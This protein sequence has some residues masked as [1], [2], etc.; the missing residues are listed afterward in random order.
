MKD[1]YKFIKVKGLD[2]A[3]KSIIQALVDSRGELKDGV[4]QV[5]NI[6]YT[7]ARA[8][9]PMV[10]LMR[11]A[12]NWESFNGKKIPRDLR[13]GFYTKRVS[14]PN[15]KFGVPVR[16]G[17]LRGSLKKESHFSG[18]MTAKGRVWTDEKYASFIERGTARMSPRPFMQPAYDINK[19]LIER[20]LGRGREMGSTETK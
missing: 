6:I 15:A 12:G 11:V 3:K 7:T 8:K 2:K 10:N 17:N 4:D 1:A 5:V 20:V 9:R 19:N 16:T 18:P 14:D 13:E